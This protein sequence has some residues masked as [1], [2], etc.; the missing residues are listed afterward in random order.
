M[1]DDDWEL[2]SRERQ[3]LARR[4]KKQRGKK[5]PRHDSATAEVSGGSTRPGVVIEVNARSATVVLPDDT[6][7]LAS[8]AGRLRGEG[9][10]VGDDVTVRVSDDGSAMVER[11]GKRRTLLSR[12]LPGPRPVEQPIVANVDVIGIVS[13]ASDP[14]LRPRLVDRYLVAIAKSGAMPLVVVNKLDEAPPERRDELDELLEPYQALDIGIHRVSAATGEGL[15]HLL[16]VLVGR[17]V[18]LVGHSG[19]GKSSLVSAMGS[20]AI[21]GGLAGHGRGRHT[22][23]GSTLHRL[24]GGTEIIDTPGVRQLGL[25]ELTKRQLLAAFP[26]LGGFARGCPYASCSHT[27]EPDCA[28][29][30]AAEAGSLSWARYDSYRRLLPEAR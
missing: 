6:T 26:D 7:V 13:A 27:D 28:V 22:T 18:A 16:E 4:S 1:Y 10:C 30:D 20:T 11:L 25:F 12:S 3:R 21:A 2:G 15:G 8:L 5:K 24:A 23:S 17:R 29:R 19:V 9:L 14:P